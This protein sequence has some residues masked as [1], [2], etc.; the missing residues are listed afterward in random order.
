M[1]LRERIRD[2]FEWQDAREWAERYCPGWLYLATQEKRP[3][4]RE[5]YRARILEA[6]RQDAEYI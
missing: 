4:L 1:T 2:W 6:Y 3:E 5:I